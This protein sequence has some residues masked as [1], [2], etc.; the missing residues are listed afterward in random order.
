MNSWKSEM[1]ELGTLPMLKMQKYTKY[2]AAFFVVHFDQP[3]FLNTE[4]LLP[5]KDP[6]EINGKLDGYIY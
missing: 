5:L 1:Q 6:D 2:Y 3:L 4:P